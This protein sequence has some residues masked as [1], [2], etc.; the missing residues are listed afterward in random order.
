MSPKIAI[1]QINSIVGDVDYNRRLIYDFSQRAISKNADIVVTPE[2]SLTGYPPKDL[3][4]SHQFY[5]KTLSALYT[6]AQDLA[7]IK[8]FYLLVGHPFLI[9]EK[10]FNACSI[11]SEGKIID[12]YCKNVL[13]HQDG[14]DEKRYFSSGNKPVVFAVKGIQFGI[15]ISDDAN[16]PSIPENTKKAGAEV[17]LVLGASNYNLNHH[18]KRIENFRKNISSQGLSTLFVNLVGGQD[19]LVFDGNSFALDHEGKLCVQLEHCQEDFELIR[20]E[21]GK[22][23]SGRQATTRSLEEE[24]YHVL[25]MGTR[26]YIEKNGFPGALIGLSGGIDSALTLAIAV[27]A[28]GKNRI[29]TVMMPSPYTSEISLADAK[30]MAKRLDVCHE[31]ISINECF[32]A[33]TKTLS[34]QFANKAEDT[35]EENIQARIRGTILMAL[36]NKSGKIVLTTG[37]KSELAVGYCTLYGDMAGGFAVISD[38]PKT[39]VYKLCHYRNTVSDVIPER[40]LTRAPSAELRLNQLDQDSL[41]PYDTL[42]VIIQMFMKERKSLEEIVAAGYDK[43]TVERVLFLIRR[44]E[45]KRQQAPVGI[46]ISSYGFKNNWYHPITSKFRDQS[47]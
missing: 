40:I 24:I 11:L 5:K 33:F 31:V 42:D 39:L 22:L 23:L 27:D 7:Q 21:Q 32:T 37:N 36:S 20:F 46:Q 19:E 45:Y 2:L 26:D 15:N 18:P 6:L 3:L 44:N 8:D 9:G 25:V 47:L 1:A 17:L 14:F 34:S 12:T 29:Q 41:P 28:I 16:A 43:E 10:R 30:E 38:I 13:S 35:T 4:L